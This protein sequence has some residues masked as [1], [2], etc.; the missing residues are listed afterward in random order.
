MKNGDVGVPENAVKN[1]DRTPGVPSTEPFVE[2]GPSVE[3]KSDEVATAPNDEDATFAQRERVVAAMTHS[4]DPVA[5]AELEDTTEN[6]EEDTTK[7]DDAGS[8]PPHARLCALN[9]L[10]DPGRDAPSV[11]ANEASVCQNALVQS[12]I[13]RICMIRSESS[14]ERDV[15]SGIGA[16]RNALAKMSTPQLSMVR[17]ENSDE[18]K[19]GGGGHV[20]EGP[21]LHGGGLV[22]VG[23]A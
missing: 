1:D 13:P 14:D 5:H 19:V 6:P 22:P 17:C 3:Y 15:G 21:D 20:Y 10:R 9:E 8:P 23:R 18:R 2:E 4:V 7:E 12:S 16:M 11:W